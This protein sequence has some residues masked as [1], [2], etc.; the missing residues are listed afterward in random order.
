VYGDTRAPHSSLDARR[1]AGTTRHRVTQRVGARAR[2]RLLRYLSIAAHS[3]CLVCARVHVLQ[4]AGDLERLVDEL[5]ELVELVAREIAE[6]K[7]LDLLEK[8][9]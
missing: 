1:T 5:A 4:L 9:H 7:A 3:L 6:V 2:A 8:V